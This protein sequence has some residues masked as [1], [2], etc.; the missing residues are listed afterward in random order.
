MCASEIRI[1][2]LLY[3]WNLFSLFGGCF[4]MHDR[5]ASAEDLLRF[6]VLTIVGYDK[7]LARLK[8]AA[9]ASREYKL[10]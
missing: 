8:V 3:C 2:A 5:D 4:G 1:V 10:I 6:G 7:T 9:A